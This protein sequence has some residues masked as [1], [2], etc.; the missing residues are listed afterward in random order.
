MTIH[1]STQGQSGL[2]RYFAA[3]FDI[4]SKMNHGR[5]D[6]KLPDGRI[7]RAQGS[8]AGPAV[9]LV[10]HNTDCF[11]RLIREGDLG[12]SD[13]YIDGWW[14]VSDLQEFMDMVLDRNEAIFDGFPGMGFVRF[15]ERLR[16]WM[17]S[18][19]R[20]QA[21]KNIAHHYDLGNE[22]YSKWLD[23]TMTYSS[24]IFESPQDDL[25]K[26]Q[27]AKYCPWSTRWV[28]KKATTFWKSAA[29]GVASR[30]MPP[31]NEG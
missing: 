24:A 5:L 8:E 7:F 4:C 9:E 13:A 17:N 20:E 3:V 19:T 6:F 2:P 16:H 11:A 30:N 18:N 10:V 26:A 29:A 22:F 15:F 25:A 23:E 14:E 12:F 21:K 31:R 27:T 28:L 1:T